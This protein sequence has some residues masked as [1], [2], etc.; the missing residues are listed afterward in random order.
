[1]KKLPI[2]IGILAS[3]ASTGFAAEDPIVVR[4]A[5]MQ[6]NAAA[7]GVAG[8]I[9]KDELAYAPALG[10]SSIMAWNAVGAAVGDYF[11]EGTA[12]PENDSDAAP[13][14]WEDMAGFQAAL[15]KFQTDVANAM[16][17]GVTPDERHLYPSFPYASY[18]RMTPGDVAD[19]WAFLG[20][21]P[22][23]VGRAPP[24]DLAFPYGIRRGIGLWKL[25]FLT[26]APAVE[27]DASDPLVARG[28][29]LVE[30][31]GHCGECHTPR[32]AAGAMDTARWLGG[33]PSPD[34]EGRIPNTTPGGDLADWSPGDIAYYLETGFT[35]E[36]DSVGGAMVDVQENLAM[37][38]PDDRAAIAA[39]LKA[40]PPVTP[41][42]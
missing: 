33:A 21:L 38:P 31:P 26:D 8:A 41:P 11:P 32:N 12:G 40:V 14:I 24:H 30:G 1:V 25:A 29:Y 23:V 22:P 13:K 5:L 34:G 15:V 42:P 4:Q 10:K 19:L 2:L 3:L 39:Y 36:F 17:R 20:T 16:Q 9:L 18:I 7:A 35:P 27:I 28:Q 37:L 6:S